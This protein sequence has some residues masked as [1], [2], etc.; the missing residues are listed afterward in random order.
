MKIVILAAGIGS[1]LGNPF[2]KPLTPLKDGETIMEKQLN[3]ISIFFDIDNVT[4]VV[5]FKKDL[6]MEEF[7]DVNYVYNPF[8]DETNTSKSLLKALKKNR[9]ESVLWFNGDVVFDEQLLSL[10]LDNI[11]KDISFV[12]VNTSRVAE[13]EVKY[14]LKDGYISELS[15]EVQNALEKQ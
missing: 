11:K 12:S 4:T 3:H 13:E 8:F 2:P 1:R 10:L 5:G 14:T 9:G 15:K 6:I 7:P